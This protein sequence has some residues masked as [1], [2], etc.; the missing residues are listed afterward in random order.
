ME[1]SISDILASV[2]HAHNNALG[3]DE[4]A[5]QEYDLQHL[6][7]AWIAERMAPELLPY[8]VELMERTM[9]RT[10]AQA[11]HEVVLLCSTLANGCLSG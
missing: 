7:R 3:S 5:Q 6:T 9:T 10:R 8:P 1:P 4:S 11:C 2:T